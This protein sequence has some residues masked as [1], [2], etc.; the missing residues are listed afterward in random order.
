MP[1]TIAFGLLDF[2]GRPEKR[3]VLD[4][5]EMSIGSVRFALESPIVAARAAVTLTVTGCM[6]R[7]AIANRRQIDGDFDGAADLPVK[8]RF[9]RTG[10]GSVPQC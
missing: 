3:E 7:L 5:T 10:S 6:T 1:D 9:Q 2:R 8:R 4:T